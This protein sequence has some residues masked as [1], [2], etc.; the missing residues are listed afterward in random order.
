MIKFIS[1]VGLSTQNLFV[2]SLP[3]TTA[4]RR[5]TRV[6]VLRELK[7]IQEVFDVLGGVDAVM[8]ITGSKRSA[9][10]NWI[11]YSHKFPS[12]VYLQ[13]TPALA[14]HNCR[15]SPTLFN[16]RQPRSKAAA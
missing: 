14:R 7:T 15:A 4:A 10:G 8:T 9:V 6:N 3:N 2:R 5:T 1:E 13:I 11:W 12:S 16:M